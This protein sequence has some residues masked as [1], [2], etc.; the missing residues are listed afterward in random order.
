[1][2][3]GE[4][5]GFEKENKVLPTWWYFCT[6]EGGLVFGERREGLQ[7]LS[8]PCFCLWP[9]WGESPCPIDL[10]VIFTKQKVM[11]NPKC[12]SCH[13]NRTRDQ[14]SNVDVCSVDNSQGFLWLCRDFITFPVVMLKD[15]RQQTITWKGS[16]HPLNMEKNRRFN[17]RPKSFLKLCG[18]LVV[19]QLLVPAS[20]SMP[21][22]SQRK[23]N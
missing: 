9:H 23:L 20:Q 21:C 18:L 17:R 12:S 13:R 1:M 4:G 15:S 22:W 8:N 6:D 5:L 2:I 16:D 19:C 14:S 10:M 11:G 7:H 3:V